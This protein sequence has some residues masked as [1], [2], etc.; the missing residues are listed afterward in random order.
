MELVDSE[1]PSANAQTKVEPDQISLR[2]GQ[3]TAKAFVGKKPGQ[4]VKMV[5]TAEIC[6][7]SLSENYN[8]DS[9][10]KYHGNVDL[11]ID[12]IQISDSSNPVADLLDDDD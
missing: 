9:R 2:L 11:E 8:P 1:Q 7:V 5:V 12:T 10:E 3:K 6:C 4:T